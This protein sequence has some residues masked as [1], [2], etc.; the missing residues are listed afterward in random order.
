MELATIS[1]I[2]IN[3]VLQDILFVC[4]VLGLEFKVSNLLG[5]PST[6]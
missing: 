6:T 4:V 2:K 5:R 1:E 3:T